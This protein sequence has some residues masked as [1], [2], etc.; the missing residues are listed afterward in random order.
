MHSQT[1]HIV[2][3]GLSQVLG[4]IHFINGNRHLHGLNAQVLTNCPF[5]SLPQLWRGPGQKWQVD[6][7]FRML[8]ELLKVIL[9]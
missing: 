6:F 8:V 7:T 5:R 4:C 3:L 1:R 2:I 9:N